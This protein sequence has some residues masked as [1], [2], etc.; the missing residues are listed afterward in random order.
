MGKMIVRVVDENSKVLVFH[1]NALDAKEWTDFRYD[2]KQ[3]NAQVKVFPN[4]LTCKFLSETKY[5]N[6]NP[7][8]RTDTALAFGSEFDLKKVLKVMNANSKIQLIGGKLDD[9]LYN[10]QQIIEY[11]K[12]PS[13]E[14]AR[15]ELVQILQQPAQSLAR[16][17]Q[18]NQNQLSRLLQ[19]HVV[20]QNRNKTAEE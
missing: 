13:L 16:S 19:I 14:E 20:E 12:L 18:S 4:K 2:M 15:C 9:A 6:M 7:L 1:Y 8:F 17:L 10:R 5:R 3:E 11:S